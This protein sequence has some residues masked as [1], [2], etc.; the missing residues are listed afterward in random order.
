MRS[1]KGVIASDLHL[2]LCAWK[3][4]PT[5]WG[6]SYFALRQIVDAAIDHEL[7]FVALLGDIF[8]VKLPDAHTVAFAYRQIQRLREAGVHVYFIQGQ[9]ELVRMT[10]WMGVHPWPMHM[11]RQVVELGGRAVYGLDWLPAGS[12]QAELDKIPQS[13]E[14]LFAHQVWQDFHGSKVQGECR[15]SD[16]PGHV[17]LLAT[18]DFHKHILQQHDNRSRPMLVGSPG[19]TCMQSIN[20]QPDKYMFF[21][22]DDLS[23]NSVELET[24]RVRHMRVEH[25]AQLDELLA[26]ENVDYFTEPQRAVPEHIGTNILRVT[27]NDTIPEV[28][29]RLQAAFRGKLHLFL[30]PYKPVSREVVIEQDARR[31]RISGGLVGVVDLVA[32]PDT[33]VNRDLRRL[34][35]SPDPAAELDQV[36]ADFIHKHKE[37]VR[38]AKSRPV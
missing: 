25:A 10:T 11:H 18:G 19:A 38:A 13:A 22:N 34:L 4:R 3:D 8:N 29:A 27:Y 1:A 23:L 35:N 5:L 21:F 28:Y 14:A 24:R 33:A 7:E 30:D 32:A 16:V 37:Q 31:E 20:E 15:F 6:D 36:R 9:H 17:R 26:P 12:I 2:E